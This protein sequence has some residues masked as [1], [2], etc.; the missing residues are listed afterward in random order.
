MI[1]SKTDGQLELA[2]LEYL[3]E[4]LG[5][6]FDVNIPKERK[7][8]QVNKM[9]CSSFKCIKWT[10]ISVVFMTCGLLLLPLHAAAQ[11]SPQRDVVADVEK[12]TPTMQDIEAVL[13]AMVQGTY[14]SQLDVNHDGK[15]D[16]KDVEIVTE[17]YEKTPEGQAQLAEGTKQ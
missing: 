15:V 1:R 17:A 16:I 9:N 11:N 4:Q 13:E 14:N 8:V 5:R 10:C 6:F 2:E 12:G 7:E 3:K